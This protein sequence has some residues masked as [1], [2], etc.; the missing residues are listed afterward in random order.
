MIPR[1][2]GKVG[3]ADK[4]NPPE[5]AEKWYFEVWLTTIGGGEGDSLGLFGPWD[6]EEVAQTQMRSLVKELSE[7]IVKNTEGAVPGKYVDMKTNEV[8]SW[9]E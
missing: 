6:T 4:D 3:Q 7:L 1:L 9:D 5:V 8:R 2:R